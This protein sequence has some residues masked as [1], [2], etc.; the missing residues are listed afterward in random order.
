MCVEAHVSAYMVRVGAATTSR[1]LKESGR[2]LSTT[3]QVDCETK[4]PI[5]SGGA[6]LNAAR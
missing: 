3:Y 1:E 5:Y 4:I 2:H 6:S